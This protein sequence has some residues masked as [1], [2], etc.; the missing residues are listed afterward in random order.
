M[1]QAGTDGLEGYSSTHKRPPAI[2]VCG[3]S[4]P[5]PVRLTPRK[6]PGNHSTGGWMSHGEELDDTGIS[7]P[8]P[9]G[10]EPHTNPTILGLGS[11]A[12]PVRNVGTGWS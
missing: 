3:W 9:P 8:P 1:C 7:R 5:R 2:E 12:L 11:V 10:I 6:R 4:A